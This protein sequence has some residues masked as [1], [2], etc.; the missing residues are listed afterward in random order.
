MQSTESDPND[1]GH[2]TLYQLCG[3]LEATSL[4]HPI[5]S[6]VATSCVYK[7]ATF[8]IPVEFPTN[9]QCSNILIAMHA[10]IQTYIPTIGPIT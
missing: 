2:P 6:I 7:I 10:Y 1:L 4:F 8:V 3:S 9:N 5:I